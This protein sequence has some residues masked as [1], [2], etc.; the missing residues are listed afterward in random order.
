MVKVEIFGLALDETGKSPIIVLKDES[1]TMVL[2]IWIGA[3][4]AMAISI[5]INKVPFPRP[6]DPRP[7][8]QYPHH[9]GR[10]HQS[11]RSDRYREWDVFFLPRSWLPLKRKPK[12]STAVLRMLLLWQYAPNVPSGWASRSWMRP[13]HRSPNIARRS[14]GPKIPTSGWTSLIKLAE[15]DTKY[16][17]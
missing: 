9:P 6:H 3:M 5:A 2:P 17:M 16:K 4:E 1:D 10:Y 15:E 14:S 8:S 11:C 12:G 13:E 7:A